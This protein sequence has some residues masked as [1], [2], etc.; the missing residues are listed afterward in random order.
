MGCSACGRRTCNCPCG[1][2]RFGFG[3]RRRNQERVIRELLRDLRGGGFN[4]SILTNG[5]VEFEDLKV[6]SFEDGVVFTVDEEGLARA[7]R[8]DR[9]DS[10]DF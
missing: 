6:I 9:I 1:I 4:T 7:F 2:D 8:I 10:V 5:G 3:R